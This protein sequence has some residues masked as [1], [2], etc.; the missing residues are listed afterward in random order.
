MTTFIRRLVLIDTASRLATRI[1][2]GRKTN[3][4]MQLCSQVTPAQIEE[5]RTRDDGDRAFQR[6]VAEL[7]VFMKNTTSCCTTQI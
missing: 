6:I 3:I 5:F 4:Q 1:I 7:P 2:N